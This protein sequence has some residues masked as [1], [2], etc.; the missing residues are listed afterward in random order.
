M[1]LTDLLPVEKWK[2][3]ELELTERSGLSANIFDTDGIR[4]TDYHFWPNALCTAVKDTDKGQAFICAVAHMNL[5][6]MA[7]Q[8]GEH[9]IEEC[10]AG[11]V[12]LVVPVTVDGEFL[13]A[14]GACGLLLDDGEVDDFLVNK[15]TEIDE[16]TVVKLSEGIDAI[17]EADLKALGDFIQKR[18]DAIISDY[19]SQRNTNQ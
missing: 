10:D 17:S 11:L 6:A 1:E 13:G 4:I 19:R 7:K 18:L 12:K 16:E 3:F 8:S 15:I 14:V 9:V 5:A 2:E